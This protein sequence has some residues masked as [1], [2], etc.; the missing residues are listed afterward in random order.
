MFVI[1][2]TQS[3]DTFCVSDGMSQ[4]PSLI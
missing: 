2:T 3:L 4:P 1:S